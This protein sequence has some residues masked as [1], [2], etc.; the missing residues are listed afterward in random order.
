VALVI[1]NISIRREEKE[2]S[3][4]LIAKGAALKQAEARL[5]LVLAALDEVYIGEVEKRFAAYRNEP[6]P[7][8]LPV[9]EDLPVASDPRQTQLERDFLQKGL[10]FYEKLIQPSSAEP[11]ARFQT[12]K[13]YRRVGILQRELKQY[14]KAAHSL[15]NAVSLLDRLAEEDAAEPQHRLELVHA[16]RWQ[17]IVD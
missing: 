1:S 16:Y 4:A 14:D 8:M 11:A 7:N 17:A 5:A 10:G 6:K 12:G 3:E 9:A 15:A 13:A 2:K